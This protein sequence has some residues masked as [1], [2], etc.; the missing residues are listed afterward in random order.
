MED[1]EFERLAKKVKDAC[2]HCTDPKTDC[3]G[4][5]EV[6]RCPTEFHADALIVIEEYENR[7]A[8]QKSTQPLDIKGKRDGALLNLYKQYNRLTALKEVDYATSESMHIL[9]DAIEKL[10]HTRHM[11]ESNEIA[12]MSIEKLDK[13]AAPIPEFRMSGIP[14]EFRAALDK[15][16]KKEGAE[17][18]D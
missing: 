3:E 4:C 1:R 11:E 15:Y 5:P 13:L 6:D 10:E 17:N 18:D 7:L 14:K 8:A 16:E 12:K 2:K 9:I